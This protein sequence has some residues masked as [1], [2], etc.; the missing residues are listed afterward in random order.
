M[1]AGLA[2]AGMAATAVGGVLAAN[3]ARQQGKIQSKQYKIQEQQL[4]LQREILSDQYKVKREQLEGSVVA[5][6]GKAGVKVSGSVANSLSN[7][8][9][10]LGMEESYKKYDIDMQRINARYNAKMAKVNGNKQAFATLLNT[11]S[12]LGGQAASYN[13]NWGASGNGGGGVTS[14]GGGSSKTVING[15]TVNSYSW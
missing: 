8:L 14:T 15:K 9:T 1:G 6:A 5:R 12:S 7:S 11:V 3:D 13:Y 10:E 4:A 2:I